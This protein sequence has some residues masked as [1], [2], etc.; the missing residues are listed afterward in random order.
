MYIFK[1]SFL[2][3]EICT[4]GEGLLKSTTIFEQNRRV[5]LKAVWKATKT[6]PNLKSFLACCEVWIEFAGRY[7]G[8]DHVHFMLDTIVERLTPDRVGF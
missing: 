5:I 6:M 3:K 7:F 2:S 1:L 4:F 8:I